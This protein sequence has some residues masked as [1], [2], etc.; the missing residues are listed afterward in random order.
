MGVLAEESSG[1]VGVE[2]G[3][4]GV[5][6]E[7]EVAVSTLDWVKDLGLSRVWPEELPVELELDDNWLVWSSFDMAV[8]LLLQDSFLWLPLGSGWD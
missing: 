3:A 5:V 6:L 7:D 4:G 2:G 1:T 8:E